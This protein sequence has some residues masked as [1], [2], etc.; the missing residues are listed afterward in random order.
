MTSPSK[1]T[2]GVDYDV[3]R[4]RADFPILDQEVHGKPLVYLDNAATS[5]KPRQVIDALT[6]YYTHDNS[7]VHRGVHA[8]SVRATDQYEG[9]RKKTADFINARDPREIIFVRGTTEGVNLAAQTYGMANVGE[10]DE[11]IVSAMEHHSN[12]VP[13][14]LL[15]EE[16][17]ASLRVIPMN[18]AGELL[19]DEYEKLLNDRTKMVAVVHISNS[20]GTVNPVERIIE[21]A[22]AR[23]VPVL[24]D[25]AQ[26]APHMRVDVQALDVDFYTLSSHKMYGP[27]GVGALFGKLELLEEMPPYQGGGD[28]IR[29]V[30]FEE[31]TYNTVP[32]R[33]EAGT[34]NVGDVVAFGTAI[35]YLNGI[36]F[37]AI[38]AYE[39]ELLDYATQSL[40]AVPDVKLIGTAEHKA[41]IVSF[42]VDDIHP[43]DIGTILDREGVAIRTGHH[44]TQPIMDFYGVPATSRASFGIYNTKAEVDALIQ[45][46]HKAKEVFA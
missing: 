28:M 43:H 5:Q 4:I 26:A 12:I 2:H 32:Q 46:L 44:C 38:Q 15:C 34:P 21:L 41:G 22:R 6:H 25:G 23:N 10:G 16:T 45:A 8:L 17:G 27:T 39:A 18:E 42:L 19:I 31:T 40:L 35:D 7:N 33:F 9:T 20:L 29:S 11:V 13:W 37:E 36:G 14:Q 1:T 24:L 30:S 3:D